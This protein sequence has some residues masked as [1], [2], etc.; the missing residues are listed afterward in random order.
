MNFRRWII[1]VLFLTLAQASSQTV[2]DT[3]V[4]REDNV[5]LD[6]LY[7]L[8]TTPPP[9]QGYPAI[10]L[11][12]G[13]G[14]SKND[15]RA[16][17]LDYARRGYASAAY[18]VRGQGSSGG[19]F[20]FFGSDAILGDLRAMIDFTA[21]LPAVN[22]DRIG[23]EGGSQGGIH[24]WMAAAHRMNV[25]AVSSIIANGRFEEDWMANG[26]MNWM[27]AAAMKSDQVRV[28]QSLRDA[29]NHAIE[30]GDHD[31]I[32]SFLGTQSTTGMEQSVSTPVAMY[33]SYHDGFFDP[34]AALRQT[35]Q[36]PG[37]RRIVLY[38]GG[39]SLPADP[40]TAGYIQELRNRWWSYWLKD[41]SADASVIDKDSTVV[42]FDGA[43]NV[44]RAFSAADSA[45][46]IGSS[47][48]TP[49]GIGTSKLYLAADSIRPLPRPASQP[50]V[51]PYIVLIGSTPYSVRS[52]PLEEDMVIA[53]IPG[54]ARIYATATSLRYQVNV[55]ILD[56]DP[57]TGRRLPITRGQ[58]E[59][60]DSRTLPESWI[61][62]PLN[63]V[64]HTVRAGHQIEVHVHS[65][66]ALIPDFNVHFGNT[67]VPPA[68][69]GIVTIQT[70][71]TT[72]SSV[73]FHILEDTPSEITQAA[74]LSSALGM[75]YPHPVLEHATL[76]IMLKQAGF[77]DVAMFDL[78]G[79]RV[80][81]LLE[82]Y[83]PAGEH[84]ISFDAS[85]RSPGT[86]FIRV[87][88]AEGMHSRVVQV[89]R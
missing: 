1:P 83:L 47:A 6:A 60:E 61:D 78:R 7:V 20:D 51:L 84:R 76:R 37:A 70:G 16:V 3:T 12:H 74:P 41:N 44:P 4:V 55:L 38:P 80:A 65:G 32:R 58:Y 57:A 2:V 64:L 10:L 36:L 17:A 81:S 33:V 11:V 66:T 85:P 25:R 79:R 43:T 39:H 68:E 54:N 72:P 69:N 28:V 59:V 45:Y 73:E 53:S 42:L 29:V 71:S 46:W 18:S 50:I 86:Y 63:A 35:K 82:G 30:T 9:V 87:V 13:F 24:A 15:N 8:P 31:D 56:L 40:G 52:A 67:P 62:I 22:P 34:G 21:G 88:S 89:V 27:F 77:V 26:A 75:P 14:G 48:F 5:T 49:P 19:Q 23:V